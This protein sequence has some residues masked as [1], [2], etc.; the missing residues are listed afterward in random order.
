MCCLNEPFETG[1]KFRVYCVKARNFSG[2]YYCAHSWLSLYD[3]GYSSW[4]LRVSCCK[5]LAQ[6]VKQCAMES[7]GE[8]LCFCILRCSC[9]WWDVGPCHCTPGTEP[10][11]PTGWEVGLASE[12]VWT[13][14][15]RECWN[16]SK[17][18]KQI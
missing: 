3:F 11:V 4:T 16:Y 13:L 17:N 10:P 5:L 18:L 12:A 8:A 9:R 14:W 15:R 2:H 1:R 7:G 6:R